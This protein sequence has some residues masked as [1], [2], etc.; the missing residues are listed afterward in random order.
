MAL[1]TV[2]EKTLSRIVGIVIVRNEDRFV[3]QAVI[4]ALDFCDQI[5]LVDNGSIDSTQEIFKELEAVH[6][7]K[8][9]LY[10]IQNPKESHDLLKRYAGTRTWIFAVDG[11]E[12]YDHKRLTEFRP[13]LISGEFDSHWMLLGN[14]HH[15]DSLDIQNGIAG[16]YSSPPGRSITKLYNFAAIKSWNGDTPER[17]HGG[18]P[19][20]LSGYNDQMKRQLQLEYS[21]EESPLRCLHLCCVPRSCLDAEQS[22][23]RENIMETYRGGWT[24]R[25]KRFF[26]KLMG[27]SE[28]SEWKRER[29]ARGE[30]AQVSTTPFF[31]VL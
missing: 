17:L 29:Y 25:V 4:N 19:E 16:G 24:N 22:G 5:L 6:P 2:E 1:G 3:R 7:G 13:R 12:I 20:F 15:C 30:R 9:K 11:D 10:H 21:W 23:S 18:V 8:L 14:V 31:T 26:R 28:M 27:Q